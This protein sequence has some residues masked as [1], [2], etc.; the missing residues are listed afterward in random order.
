[1]T[2]LNYEYFSYPKSKGL[3]LKSS[4]DSGIS[5]DTFQF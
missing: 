4:L 2:E 3:G 1:M 5:K